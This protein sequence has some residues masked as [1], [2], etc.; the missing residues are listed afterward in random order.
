MEWASVRQASTKAKRVKLLLG[1]GAYREPQSGQREVKIE[2]LAAAKVRAN[3]S[4]YSFVSYCESK[5]VTIVPFA[6]CSH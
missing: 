2:R 1:P 5:Y 6:T 3:V 4:S